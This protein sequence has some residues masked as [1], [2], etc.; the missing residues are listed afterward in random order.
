MGSV[1]PFNFMLIILATPF[2]YQIL[3]RQGV[4]VS[5]YANNI[6]YVLC[7]QNI[8]WAGCNRLALC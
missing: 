5:L 3:H 8:T 6:G 1:Q 2:V 7:L 4:T